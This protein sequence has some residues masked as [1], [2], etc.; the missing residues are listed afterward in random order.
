MQRLV[1]RWL[2]AAAILLASPAFAAFHLFK[3]DEIYS[4]ADGTV[5]FVVLTCAGCPNGESFWLGQTL[6]ATGGKSFTFPSNLPN[7]G[8]A[9]RKVLIGTQ[10][11]AALGVVA[12][13]F[14]IPNGFIPMTGTVNYAG[15]DQMSFGSLPTDGTNAV[16][17]DGSI[18]PNVATN[19]AGASGSV[20]LAPPPA[21]VVIGPG[22][23]GV[24]NDPNQNRHGIFVEVL[25]ANGFLAWWFTFTPDGTQ[26]SWFGGVGTYAGNTATISAVNLTTGGQWI[27]N[28]DVSK[29]KDNPWGTLTFTFTDCNH[30]RVD[31]V[32]TFPGYGSNHMDLTRVTQPAGLTCP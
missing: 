11:F 28:F 1:A 20:V 27:P 31:F 6:S 21:A 10:G 32:S 14:T 3:I 8:T 29:T 9:G 23:T 15:V 4:N 22:F 17:R 24:W 16:Y 7:T 18:R 25:P 30:G 26:Q 13:D 5:Q 19:F 2:A 12:P